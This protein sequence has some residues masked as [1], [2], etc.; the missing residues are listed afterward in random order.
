[1]TN[2]IT[3]PIETEE[4]NNL[5]KSIQTRLNN[6]DD[7]KPTPIIKEKKMPFIPDVLV[8]KMVMMARPTYPYI[9]CIKAMV[10]E[11]EETEARDGW[12]AMPR[13]HKRPTNWFFLYHY[14]RAYNIYNDFAEDSVF[15][16]KVFRNFSGVENLVSWYKHEKKMFP[17]FMKPGMADKWRSAGESRGDI[18][19]Y[20]RTKAAKSVFKWIYNEEP[21]KTR[22]NKKG[23]EKFEECVAN[24]IKYEID[25][26]TRNIFMYGDCDIPEF[27]T[28]THI[29]KQTL[30]ITK[31]NFFYFDIDVDHLPIQIRAVLQN[32][33]VYV[34][35]IKNTDTNKTHDEHYKA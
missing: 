8:N 21:E 16:N 12:G 7:K 29:L 35:H 26:Y 15:R 3:L 10:E 25:R 14:W 31:N 28:P 27:C 22:P 34:L 11:V 33:K 4:F 19:K 1:M 6:L 32:N 18:K 24:S 2:T 23:Y 30:R 17:L 9:N 13:W 20:Q 5:L